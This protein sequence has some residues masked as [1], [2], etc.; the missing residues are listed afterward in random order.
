[1]ALFRIQFT[2]LCAFV[3]DRP[4]SEVTDPSSIRVLLRNLLIPTLLTRADSQDPTK[5]EILD[6]HFPI[7][8]YPTAQKPAAGDL[9]VNFFHHSPS[10]TAHLLTGFDVHVDVDGQEVSGNVTRNGLSKVV[11]IDRISPGQGKVNPKFLTDP[12]LPQF[13]VISRLHLAGGN[14]FT[15]LTSAQNVAIESQGIPTTQPLG[16]IATS[17]AW[18]IQFENQVKLRFLHP[19]KGE[20][21]LTFGP[22][23]PSQLSQRIEV[24]VHNLEIDGFIDTPTEYFF[25][26]A[27]ADVEVYYKLSLNPPSIPVG[28]TS[29]RALVPTGASSPGQ[30]AGTVMGGKCPGVEMSTGP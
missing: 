15:F 9:P 12:L 2:G 7:L 19:T 4:F 18:E 13:D 26:R 1:M 14:I 28:A 25:N 22:P 8:D 24:R 11:S 29:L 5:R 6:A 27:L 30:L 3:P 23:A 17:L 16:Q 10:F 20:S 21:F